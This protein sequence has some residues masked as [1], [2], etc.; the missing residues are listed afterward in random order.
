ML[1]SEVSPGV[2]F[3]H[4]VPYFF[5]AESFNLE[6][7]DSVTLASQV[8]PGILLSP[9][10]STET[11]GTHSHVSLYRVLMLCS[12]HFTH[13]ATSPAPESSFESKSFL[14]LQLQL[15]IPAFYLTV[16]TL[17]YT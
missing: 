8:P 3:D 2:I 14:I 6:L 15:T 5:K 12:K 17:S 1:R 4:Y 11:A 7:T 13:E 10:S 9:T 16:F